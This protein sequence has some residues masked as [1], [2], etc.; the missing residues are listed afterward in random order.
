MANPT[1]TQKA[2]DKVTQRQKDELEKL[3][4]E[5]AELLAQNSLKKKGETKPS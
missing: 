4:R 1:E 2:L 3:K 5:Q